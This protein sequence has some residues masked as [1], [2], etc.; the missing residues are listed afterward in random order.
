MVSE[1]LAQKLSLEISRE[2][3]L[4]Y[5]QFI[6]EAMGTRRGRLDQ[7]LERA[8]CIYLHR[9]EPRFTVWD[10]TTGKEGIRSATGKSRQWIVIPIGTEVRAVL[11]GRRRPRLH[12]Y[13]YIR[14]GR[15]AGE[16]VIPVSGGE[17]LVFSTF[18]GAATALAQ[19][20]GYLG[21]RSG[22]TTFEME[23]RPNQ[24]VRIETLLP[25]RLPARL[26]RT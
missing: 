24:W 18:G 4:Q 23:W 10:T 13:G 26:A 6:V 19:L 12:I 20:N 17:D 16:L 2:E 11:G 1:G 15:W 3:Y 8:R 14:R 7:D 5:Q 22:S 9:P 25:V 21:R